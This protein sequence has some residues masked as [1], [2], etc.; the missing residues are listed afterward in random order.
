VQR[1]VDQVAAVF[2][3]VVLVIALIT[4]LGWLWTGVP[5]EEALL[6]AVA[7]LV[8]ACPCALGLATPAAIMAGT[9]VAAQH[10]ILIKDAQALE[11]AHRVDTLAFD[12][13]GTLTEGH[14]RL[15]LIEAV[16]GVDEVAVLRAA[17]ALQAQS[18]HPLALAVLEAARE[19][20]IAPEPA[21]EV[22]AVTGRGSQGTVQGTRLA[23]GSLRPGGA[24]AP[25]RPGTAPVHGVRRQRRRRPGHGRPPGPARRRWR[26][27]RRGAAG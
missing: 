20:G 11:I 15:T 3:P 13:T 19:R 25:A 24:D 17:A 26:G 18:A 21:Q 6:H 5:V 23:L 2:V 1:L 9:G 12:K 10:G 4:L 8:I 7:V 27:H 16:A 22:Q 14:P